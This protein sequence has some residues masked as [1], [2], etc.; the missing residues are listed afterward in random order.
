MTTGAY[1]LLLLLHVLVFV[2][3]LGSDLAVLYAAKYGSDKTLAFET[4]KTISE[5]MAFV[6]LFPR[7]SVPL[8]GATGITMG[9]LSGALHFS[10][11][12]V[13]VT[14]LAALVWILANLY[15]FINRS[16]PDR[17][18]NVVRFDTFWRATLA[19]VIAGAATASFLGAGITASVSLAAKLLLY[20]TAIALS[21]VL[22]ILFRPYRPALSRIATG[23]DNAAESAIMEKA[24]DRA[25]PVVL[26]IW[27]LTIAAAAIGLWKPY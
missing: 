25:R 6:D 14:W 15:V 22:R 21:L 10:G 8:I 17:V 12:W 13:W 11:F 24:L 5:I 27:A 18:R 20:A 9:A 26:S 19:V 16:N 2:Y 1:P 3:W 23:G 4:R 7:L